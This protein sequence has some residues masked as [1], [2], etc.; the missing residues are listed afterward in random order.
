MS[1][2]LGQGLASG[3]TQVEEE[4]EMDTAMARAILPY[5]AFPSG[6]SE[7]RQGSV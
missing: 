1:P 3:S 4:V 2:N 7:A 6:H 5:G